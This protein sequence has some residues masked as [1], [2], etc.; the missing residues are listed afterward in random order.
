MSYLQFAINYSCAKAYEV[1]YQAN[2][3]DLTNS[4]KLELMDVQKV[5]LG[6]AK[7]NLDK[8][9]SL[10]TFAKDTGRTFV[11]G[12]QFSF[13]RAMLRKLPSDNLELIIQHI[14]ELATASPIN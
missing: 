10:E 7:E 2:E 4:E 13:G 8:M 14:A 3:K 1:S 12:E 6:A 5:F 11:N 9:Q